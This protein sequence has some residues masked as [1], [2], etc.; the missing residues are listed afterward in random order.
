MAR[1]GGR[2]VVLVGVAAKAI[3]VLQAANL[4]I[5]RVVDEAPLKIGR[6][7]P[8][9]DLLIEPL[10][11]VEGIDGPCFF[12]IGAWNFARELRDKIRARRGG[13]DLCCTYFPSVMVDE[14]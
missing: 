5:D 1:E 8:G 9:T 11:A 3:T 14:V 12:V 4:Q 7:L 10:D 2:Q 13:G 6:Y